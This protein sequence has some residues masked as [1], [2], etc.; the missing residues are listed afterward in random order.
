MLQTK[1][2][3]C[4][5]VNA[6]LLQLQLIKILP[7]TGRLECIGYELDTCKQEIQIWIIPITI[8]LMMI[9]I[10]IG[11]KKIVKNKDTRELV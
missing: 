9:V 5:N 7:S 4:N 11:M 10:V 3:T 1:Y 6:P 8:I 2:K